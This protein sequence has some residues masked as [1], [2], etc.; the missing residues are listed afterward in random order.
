[1]STFGFV[2][3]YSTCFLHTKCTQPGPHHMST[4]RITS[5]TYI[6]D[7]HLQEAR[8]MSLYF[9]VLSLSNLE[10]FMRRPE[11]RQAAG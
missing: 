2:G 1:M 9:L 4:C 5:W 11:D 10:S 7:L 8:L 6:H 3:S